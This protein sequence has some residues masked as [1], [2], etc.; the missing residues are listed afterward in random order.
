MWAYGKINL[1]Q[2]SRSVSDACENGSDT[3]GFHKMQAISGLPDGI[4]KSNRCCSTVFVS[5]LFSSYYVI[6]I[7]NRIKIL[8]A[9][10]NRCTVQTVTYS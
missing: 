9:T 4:V 2:N 6:Y 3:S 5:R 10:F 1:I 8:L 7:A